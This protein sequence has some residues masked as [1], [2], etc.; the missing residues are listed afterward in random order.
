MEKP[1]SLVWFRLDLRL[2]DQPA[3]HAA[4]TAGGPVIPVFIH[5]PD[6]EAPWEPGA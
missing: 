4:I 3:L 2:N 5:A 1:N 6:E